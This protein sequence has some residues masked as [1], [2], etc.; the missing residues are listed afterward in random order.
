MEA[1][2]RNRLGFINVYKDLRR[3]QTKESLRLLGPL[4]SDHDAKSLNAKPEPPTIPSELHVVRST[5]LSLIHI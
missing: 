2:R 1:V 3:P 5:Q 4:Y